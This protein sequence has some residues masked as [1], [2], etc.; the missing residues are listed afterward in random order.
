MTQTTG[1]YKRIREFLACIV[2]IVAIA[3]FS[4]VFALFWFALFCFFGFAL[5]C[6]CIIWSLSF[7][8]FIFFSFQPFAELE[9]YSQW[10]KMKCLAVCRISVC[11]FLRLCVCV[12]LCVCVSGF[13]ICFEQRGTAWWC[14]L[15]WCFVWL[16]M[17]I[18]LGPFRGT[19]E[20]FPDDHFYKQCQMQCKLR[21]RQT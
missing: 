20:R 1:R 6:F 9:F 8:F 5:F 17:R 16:C 18:W 19:T 4:S 10:K 11:L 7:C 13:F 3:H 21:S 15:L 12:C 14:L 2:A